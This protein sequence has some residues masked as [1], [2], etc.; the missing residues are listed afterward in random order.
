MDKSN[1]LP[2]NI[3]STN[4]SSHNN[5]QQNQSPSI[6]NSSTI[7][8]FVSA[9]NIDHDNHSLSIATSSQ[10]QSHQNQIVEYSTNQSFQ[11]LLEQ[12]KN[13]YKN[14]ITESTRLQYLSAN[15]GFVI[16]LF[17][18]YRSYILQPHLDKYKEW[19]ENETS[20]NFAKNIK[21]S[22]QMNTVC[23]FD[24]ELVKTDVFLTYLL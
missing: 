12:A 1:I 20:N 18:N 5:N 24:L 10:D 19:F 13:V 14:Q 9:S 2:I 23:P 15:T 22:L 6:H 11:D 16:F 3:G 4:N 7:T 17:R 21:D 8:S